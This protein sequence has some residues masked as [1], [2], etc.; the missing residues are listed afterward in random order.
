MATA[1]DIRLVSAQVD[2]AIERRVVV[3]KEL[4]YLLGRSAGARYHPGCRPAI[5]GPIAPI[6]D[7]IHNPAGRASACAS[8]A[9][10]ARR[11]STEAV[12][13]RVSPGGDHRARHGPAPGGRG[14][15]GQCRADRHDLPAGDQ[16]PASGA[17]TGPP[18]LLPGRLRRR[19][20]PGG[21]ER[22]RLG[23]HQQGRGGQEDCRSALECAARRDGRGQGAAAAQ[24]RRWSVRRPRTWTN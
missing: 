18:G 1:T 2:S 13:P 15:R 9:L 16:G 17:E 4:G 3:A 19:V 22:D 11:P 12:R 10:K 5:R 24:G 23:G 6:G 21:P 8:A 20:S 7:V 14:R